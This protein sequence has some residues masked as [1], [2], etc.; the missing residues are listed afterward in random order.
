MDARSC[1]THPPTHID[2]ARVPTG[3]TIDS[4]D[5]GFP[6]FLISILGVCIFVVMIGYVRDEAPLLET[7]TIGEM[8]A[9]ICALEMVI[10]GF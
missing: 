5:L 9:I 8:V 2:Y 3:S 1:D 10:Y 7:F 6:S 4:S